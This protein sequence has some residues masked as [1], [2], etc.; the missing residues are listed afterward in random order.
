MKITNDTSTSFNEDNV[1][2]SLSESI[3]DL[4]ERRDGGEK[5]DKWKINCFFGL[6]RILTIEITDDTIDE[7]EEKI[8]GLRQNIWKVLSDLV[9]D[10]DDPT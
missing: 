2:P 6:G 1:K 10:F 3:D 7:L 4:L 8:G 9:I 5:Q